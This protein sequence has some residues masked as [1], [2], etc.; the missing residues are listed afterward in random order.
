MSSHASGSAKEQEDT[1]SMKLTRWI[2]AIALL[3]LAPSAFAGWTTTILRPPVN[4]RATGMDASNGNVLI[5]L[6]YDIPNGERAMLWRHDTSSFV[7]LNGTSSSSMS[8]G[9]SNNIQVG[10]YLQNGIQHACK[11]SGSA[12]SRSDLNPTGAFESVARVIS[13]GIIAGCARF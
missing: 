4:A 12:D 1:M 7:D 9:M 8:Y 5:Y 2:P 10:Y 6:G 13:G 3:A 11:W